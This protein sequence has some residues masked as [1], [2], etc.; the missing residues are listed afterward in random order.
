MAKIYSDKKDEYERGGYTPFVCIVKWTPEQRQAAIATFLRGFTTPEGQGVQ[1]V[2]GWDLIGRNTMILIGWMNSAASL[3][4]FCASITYE[5]GLSIDVCPA[6]DHIA[7]KKV[8][9]GLRSRLAKIR[10]PK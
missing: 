3:Q 6:I 1:G 7:L 4:K 10:V 5:T 9:G 8:L 2:H